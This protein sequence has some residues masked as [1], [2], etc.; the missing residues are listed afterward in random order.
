MSKRERPAYAKQQQQQ[1][2]QQ[3]IQLAAFQRIPKSGQTG[4]L[5]KL[6]TIKVP[7]ECAISFIWLL[8]EALPQADPAQ[9][10]SS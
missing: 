6:A 5:E 8:E 2:L 10:H 9:V 4:A 7:P 3:C 1:Q